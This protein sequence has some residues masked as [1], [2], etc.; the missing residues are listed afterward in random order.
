MHIYG[1]QSAAMIDHHIVTGSTAVSRSRNRSIRR[2]HD[3]SAS[4]RTD[5]NSFMIGRSAS[6][7]RHTRPIITGHTRTARTRP[8]KHTSGIMVILFTG[9]SLLCLNAPDL[10]NDLLLR[11]NL[12]SIIIRVAL[13]R[14]NVSLNS[15]KFRLPLLHKRCN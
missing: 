15:G 14:I 11:L 6:H 5:V 7:R 12:R 2:S 9:S 8:G 3:R 4:G 10:G 13:C 1:I